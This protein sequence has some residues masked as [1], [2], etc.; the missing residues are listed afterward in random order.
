MKTD[1][2]CVFLPRVKHKNWQH[3][4]FSSSCQTWKLTT[5]VFFFMSN[6]KT[7]YTCVLLPH[8]KHENWHVF[9]FLMENWQ[10]MCFS[11]SCKT[12]KLTT[13]VFFFLMSNMKT[14]NTCVFL[15]HAKTDNTCVFLPLT[16]MKTDNK[17]VFLTRVKHE[18]WQQMCFS[19]SLFF[20]YIH[21]TLLFYATFIKTIFFA[22]NKTKTKTIYISISC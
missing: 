22:T 19:S 2:T 9:F 20:V 10:H 13:H 16:N 21:F 3:M 18:N 7:V 1:H 15:P 5:H 12:W 11:S 8:V 14:D 4:C 6:M 17:C